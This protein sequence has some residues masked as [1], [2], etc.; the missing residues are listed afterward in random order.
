MLVNY[1]SLETFI[2]MSLEIY[3]SS[4]VIRCGDSEINLC[5]YTCYFTNDH[6]N[7]D[8]VVEYVNKVKKI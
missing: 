8:N 1:F 7:L 5:N 3:I 2:V 6:I 4:R